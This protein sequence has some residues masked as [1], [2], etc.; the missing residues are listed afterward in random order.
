MGVSAPARSTLP[1]VP[2]L[3][4]LPKREK[5]G[6]PR[7]QTERLWLIAG[8][9]IAFVLFLIGYFFFISPQRAQTND[10]NGQV[11]TANQ[12]NNLLEN[13]IHALEEQ[14]KNLDKYVADLAQARLALPATS[15]VSDFLRTLQALGNSTLT[16]VTAVS[17]S[18]P[19]DVTPV[20][21]AQPATGATATASQTATPPAG[22]A[23]SATGVPPVTAIYSMSISAT[24]TGSPAALEKFLDQLQSVQPRAVLITQ[25]AEKSG[26]TANSQGVVA[27]TTSL[28]LTMDA[29]VAPGAAPASAPTAAASN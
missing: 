23:T 4:K 16:Q 9:L 15:G 27:A 25:I 21:A 20:S 10:V 8:G 13:R 2:K 28:D 7:S 12:Q 22:T 29:F 11:A 3:P 26:S 1:K 24:V 5:T 19:T 14:N 6:V 17:V 18:E